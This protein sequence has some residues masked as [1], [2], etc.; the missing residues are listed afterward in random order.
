MDYLVICLAALVASGLT[1]F[2]GF[3][4]GTL[5]MPVFALFFPVEVA[6]A[7]TAVVH[8]ATNLFKLA[9]LGRRADWHLVLLF[10]LPAF[11]ASFAGAWTLLWLSDLA[12][13]FT[14]TLLG[15]PLAVHPVKLVIA[16]L[17]AAFSLLELWP[18]YNRLAIA[19]RYIPA[20]GILSGFFGGLSGNQGAFRSAFLLKSGL[21]AQAFISTGVVIAALVDFS[22][23]TVYSGLLASDTVRANLALIIAATVAAFAG[24]FA[25]TRLIKRVTIST[26]R[27]VVAAML[28][29]IALLLGT[30]VI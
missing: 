1:L 12:P 16:V 19:R 2:S 10:G 29:L 3:G 9:L 6:V 24:A 14:Y 20:G 27:Y 17:M 28:L 18:A 23:L 7:Q 21:S 5:L 22:R 4:L 25:G 8:F 15:Q 26:V 13:L 11:L 30:G